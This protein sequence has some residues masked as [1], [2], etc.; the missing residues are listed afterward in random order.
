MILSALGFSIMGALVKLCGEGGIPVMEIVTA[1]S[2]VSLILSILDVKRKKLSPFGQR[3][4]LLLMR[5][6]VGVFALV[7]VY[8]AL[9][10]L[11]FA[12]AT[13]LQYLHPMFTTFLAVLFL[14]ER[15]Q[16]STLLCIGLSLLGLVL[17]VR[18]EFAFGKNSANYSQLALI[19][20]IAGAFGSALAYVLVRQLSKT[21]DPSV[22]ILYFP[23]IALPVALILLGD[24]FVWPQGWQWLWLTLV[25]VATQVGQIGLTKAMQ[26]ETASKTT[27]YAYLQV[28]F[29]AVLGYVVFGEVPSMWTWL[30]S[31]FI[32]IGAATSMLWK[33]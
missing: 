16:L 30:G 28:V 21:E 23:V 33:K 19:A 13:V 29:A 11:P 20:A 3:K 25:G 32:L 27:S 12:E 9:T 7:C 26:V 10:A 5:G 2:L 31:A 22:I 17:I 6:V 18:P 24:G 15:L 8:Y 4:G 14:R 1:R